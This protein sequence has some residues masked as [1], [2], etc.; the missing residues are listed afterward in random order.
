MFRHVRLFWFIEGKLEYW[1]N[2]VDWQ[3]LKKA[4]QDEFTAT[5]ADDY[6]AKEMKQNLW[7][8]NNECK[9]KETLKTAEA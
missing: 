4:C 1:K 8:M 9:C 3:T 6:N 2:Y 7:D 5:L